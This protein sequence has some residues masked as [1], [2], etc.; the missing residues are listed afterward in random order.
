MFTRVFTFLVPFGLLDVFAEHVEASMSTLQTLAPIIPMVI[1]SGLV[2]W[3]FTTMEVIGDASEDPFERSMND[4][5][6]NALCR[7]IEID[8][9]QMLGEQDVPPPEAAIDGLLY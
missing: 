2:S 3:V 4:V 1:A 6:M 7:V 8:L 9:R 5:P